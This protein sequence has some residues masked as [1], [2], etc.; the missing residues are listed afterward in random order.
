MMMNDNDDNDVY[1]DWDEFD[2]RPSKSQLKRD[3]HELRELGTALIKLNDAT[4]KTIP[5][6]DE[7]RQAI[8]EAQR[9]NKHGALKRQLQYIGKLLRNAD[10]EIIRDA[11]QQAVNHYQQDVKQ[12]HRVEQWRDRLL[13]EGDAALGEL[14]DEAPTADRQHLRQLV[15]SANKEK[16][17]NKPPKSARELFQYLK[18]LFND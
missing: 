18:S 3:A 6:S 16:L 9:I 5:L 12:F 4:L 11:Y 14:I 1:D 17:D 8:H 10:A 2:N 15:R 7:L 13:K